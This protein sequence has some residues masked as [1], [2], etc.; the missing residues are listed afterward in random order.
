MQ[1][2]KHWTIAQSAE[3]QADLF[4]TCAFTTFPIPPRRALSGPASPSITMKIT[5]HTQF[6][7]FARYVNPDQNAAREAAN[8]LDNFNQKGEWQGE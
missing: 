1:A 7:T 6:A 8:F 5:G 2:C 3:C 4:T